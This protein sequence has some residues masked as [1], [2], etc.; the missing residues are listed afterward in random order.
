MGL[1]IT[2]LEKLSG[3]SRKYI[4][5]AFEGANIS[6]TILEKLSR[7]LGI[8]AIKLGGIEID[9]G[10]SSLSNTDLALATTLLERGLGEAMD[11]FSILRRHDVREDPIAIA[12]QVTAGI[13]KKKSDAELDAET[14]S[15]AV[16]ASARR[17]R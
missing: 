8:S 3:V 13:R 11:G 12:R 16:R 15:Q 6:L 14:S 10:K 17:R 7:A 1:T 4:A 9:A 2:Q 5:L